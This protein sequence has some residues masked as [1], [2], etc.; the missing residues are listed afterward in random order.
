MQ[1]TLVMIAIPIVW[2]L[3]SAVVR[4]QQPSTLGDLLDRGGAKLTKD[5]ATKLY[6]DATTSGVQGGNFQVYPGTPHGFH[7]DCRPSYRKEQAEDG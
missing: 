1:C 4:A 3:Q 6:S 5:E 7:A 2:A